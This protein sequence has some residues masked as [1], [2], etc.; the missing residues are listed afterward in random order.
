MGKAPAVGALAERFTVRVSSRRKLT[1]LESRLEYYLV[2]EL[3]STTDW[4]AALEGVETVVHCAGRAHVLKDRAADQ[5]AAFRTVNV[6]GTLKLARQAVESGV[7]RFVFISS[8]GVNEGQTAP[9]SLSD[10][11]IVGC[12]L[13]ETGPFF[14]AFLPHSW[15]MGLRMRKKLS[16]VFANFASTP[17]VRQAP[18]KSF[19]EADQPKPHNASL[20]RSPTTLNSARHSRGWR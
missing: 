14:P 12:N 8:I 1:A 16:S 11:G 10:F 9:R 20:E 19:S 3:S 7:T 13:R 5:L 15:A 17:K 18:S 2:G 6:E 4:F